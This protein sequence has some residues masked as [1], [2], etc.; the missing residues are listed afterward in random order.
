MLLRQNALSVITQEDIAISKTLFP[1]APLTAVK[2]K[3]LQLVMTPVKKQK[4]R[5]VIKQH[6]H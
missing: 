3:S 5:A 6:W 2:C 1:I 4:K